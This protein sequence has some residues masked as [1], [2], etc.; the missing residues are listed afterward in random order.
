MIR[1]GTKGK[2]E[3]W[4]LIIVGAGPAGL[5]AGI[6][7]VRSGLKTLVFDKGSGGGLV[8]ESPWVENYLGFEGIKGTKLTDRFKAHA[9][10]YVKIHELEDVK[11]IEKNK[12]FIVTT[13]ENKYKAAALILAMGGIPGKIGVEGEAKFLGKGVSYCAICDAFFFKGK[14]VIV[15]GGGNSAIV[16]AIYLSDGGSKVTLIH[17]RDQLRADQSLQR[18]LFDRNIKVIL[19]ST[20]EKIQGDKFVS[21]VK[22]KAK[23]DN[24]IQEL[25]VE[26]VFV[27]IG[28]KPNSQLAKSIGVSL[29][30]QGHIITD[31]R[32]A[33]NIP[34]VYGAG[35]ITGGLKQIITASAEGAIAAI[36]AYED[37]K[38]PYW[39]SNRKK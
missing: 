39:A 5:S 9:L 33:T 10:K 30:K 24:K 23:P 18:T 20:V 12:W 26:G 36:S 7:G 6:Y 29:D 3:H 14:K 19:N 25:K 34:E 38:N 1:E 4:D 32:Q 11:E 22:I 13:N 37:V 28:E 21:G 31:K 8:A 17:R 16:D 27:S 15:V 35:D 2:T